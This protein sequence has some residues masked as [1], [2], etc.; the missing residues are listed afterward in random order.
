MAPAILEFMRQRPPRSDFD[1]PWKE[2][3]DY[4]LAPFLELFFPLAHADINWSKRYE[5]LDKELHQ[6][7]R[8]AR[9]RKGLADK[10]FKVWRP[11]GEEAWLLIHI[12]VQGEPE[13]DFPLRMFRYNTRAFDK[14]NRTVVSLAVLT[15]E[16]PDWRP[17]RFEYGHWG[18]TTVIRF[19]SVKLLDWS[20]REAELE[21]SANP[22]AQVIL[23][24]LR[25][26]ATRQDPQGR[27]RYKLELVKGLY[28]HGWTAEDVRQLLRVVDWV[29]DLPMEL[30]QGFQEELHAW[31]EENRMPYVT[32][33]ERHGIE[34]GLQQGLQEAIA[35]IL[36]AKF[37]KAGKRL[38]KKVR[39]IGK[40]EKL[41]AFLKVCLA[42]ETLQEIRDR[43][44]LIQS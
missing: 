2:A 28:R 38:M 3:L 44:S 37:G 17:D 4:F 25:S 8:A 9:S 31:E 22:F 20:E 42:A 19:L 7:V 39:A 14:Y 5:S 18:A 43:L 23:A 27:C 21:A 40:L 13:D 32:S 33:F 11:N 16:R 6:I 15:D 26:L 35:N 10:L 29:L 12:E 30:Q 24:H 36:E 41:R 34:I 1:S